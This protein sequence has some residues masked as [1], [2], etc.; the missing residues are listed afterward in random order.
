[1]RRLGIIAVAMVMAAVFVA[2]PLTVAKQSVSVPMATM[3]LASTTTLITEQA[4]TIN[5]TVPVI[6]IS[7]AGAVCDPS[8]GLHPGLALKCFLEWLFEFTDASD[9][10]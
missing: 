3:Q 9:G 1:M 10:F 2:M 7:D 6:Q 4:S 5:F 8:G